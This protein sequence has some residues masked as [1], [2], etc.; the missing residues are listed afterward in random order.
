MLIKILSKQFVT[1]IWQMSLLSSLL[2]WIEMLT[3]GISMRMLRRKRIIV[4]A[5]LFKAICSRRTITGTFHWI[6]TIHIFKTE[7]PDRKRSFKTSETRG[8]KKK[9]MLRISNSPSLNMETCNQVLDFL[10][11][12]WLAENLL[13][14]RAATLYWKDQLISI[15]QSQLT[16]DQV[17]IQ[18]MTIQVE[19]PK[20]WKFTVF[21]T[22]QRE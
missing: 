17:K 16:W 19:M 2:V 7:F 6:I 9:I 18:S 11:K 10:L 12:T 1:L 13:R 20:V 3:F 21:L 15:W 8:T 14:M 4:E 22:K 5:N